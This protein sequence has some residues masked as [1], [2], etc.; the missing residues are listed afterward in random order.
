MAA[1]RRQFRVLVGVNYGPR[2]VRRE[3]GELVDDIPATVVAAWLSEGVIELA[4]AEPA[5]DAV[6]EN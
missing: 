2:D 3:P 5:A 6:E 4:A 1:G